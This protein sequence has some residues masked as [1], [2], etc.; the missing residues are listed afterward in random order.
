MGP[1]GV[2][3]KDAQQAVSDDWLEQALRDDAREHLSAYLPDDGFTAGVVS[4]LPQPD[5]LPAWRRPFVVL[6][7]AVVAVAVVAA[8][9]V[10]F[11]DVFR[12][13]AAFIVGQRFRLPDLAMLLAVL[14]AVSW[15]A[16]FFAARAD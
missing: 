16:L 13:A 10:W 1:G 5:A 3:S 15:S 9:P 2:M 6:L 14:G 12:N 11:D 8:L 4:R 7:W